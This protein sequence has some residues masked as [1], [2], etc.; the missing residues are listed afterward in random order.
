[1]DACDAQQHR[2][3]QQVDL[4]LPPRRHGPAFAGC[5]G[6]S[7]WDWLAD[8]GHA[9][10]SAVQ[11]PACPRPCDRPPRA[12]VAGTPLC[13]R[14]DSTQSG[15]ISAKCD[16]SLRATTFRDQVLVGIQRNLA[17]DTRVLHALHSRLATAGLAG[18]FVTDC[19]LI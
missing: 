12:R 19:V 16:N 6:V 8:H 11:P 5:G 14:Y 7:S 2:A 9:Q 13:G 10:C 18:C 1:M 15:A 4:H 17:I 3:G